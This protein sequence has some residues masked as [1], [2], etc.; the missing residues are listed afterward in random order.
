MLIKLQLAIYSQ[1]ANYNQLYIASQ[2]TI[3]IYS[4]SYIYSQLANYNYI[5]LQ[6]A[7][8]KYIQLQLYGYILTSQLAIVT[9]ITVC[10]RPLLGDLCLSSTPAYVFAACNF[11]MYYSQ[12]HAMHSLDYVNFYEHPNFCYTSIFNI[13]DNYITI[14][15]VNSFILRPQ[16]YMYS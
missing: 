6:L 3:T 2:L 5:Q 7:N 10:I 12:L 13:I 4:Y 16:R 15:R 8:Y 1:L 11:T 14:A 9:P